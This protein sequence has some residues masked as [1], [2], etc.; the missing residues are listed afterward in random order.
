MTALLTSALALGACGG[1]DAIEV[2]PADE[3]LA[4]ES[5]AP[6]PALCGAPLKAQA[7][8][9]IES[10]VARELS[11]LV[12]SRT[13]KDVLWAHNDSGDKPRLLAVSPTGRVLAEV[14][15]TGAKALDWE[16]I[17]AGRGTLL[18]GDIGDN[19]A[20]RPSIV[21]YRI[22][23]PR[24]AGSTGREAERRAHAASSCAIRTEP[25]MQRPCCAIPTAARSSWSRSAATAAA[26]STSRTRRSPARRRRCA[27][28]DGCSSAGARRSRQAT[29]PPTVARSPLRTY[30]SAF[31]WRR[32]ADESLTDAL[33]RKPCQ[34]EAETMLEEV[35]VET[36]ALTA[37]GRAFHSVP[38][39]EVPAISRYAPV[40]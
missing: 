17:A 10:P 21:V 38:E 22:D 11:G 29:C 13:Q 36:I 14:A 16:D 7:T 1:D 27:A 30:H 39:G 8:G 3:E 28:S 5:A 26:A 20:E 6:R 18:I 19:D 25:T 15:V 24:V 12:R 4:A 23:E 9:T 37:D 33:L 31:A 2:T 32:S 40:R 35:Q 34:M